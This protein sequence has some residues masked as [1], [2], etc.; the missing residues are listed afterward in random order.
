[1]YFDFSKEQYMAR[2]SARDFLGERLSTTRL[3]QLL[4][5]DTGFDRD[6]WQGLAELGWMS[7]LVPDVH[8]GLGLG[9]LDLALLLE[10]S[11]RA[12][13]PAPIVET[14]VVLPLVLAAA[15]AAQQQ[16]WL[17]RV[18]GG[19]VVATVAIGGRDGLPLPAGAG[20][21]A[22][23]AGAGY[24]L[25]GE[26]ALV[27]FASVA[28]VVLVAARPAGARPRRRSAGAG[29]E[30]SLFLVEPRDRGVSWEP[31]AG[32]DP[33]IRLG[34]LR[35]EGVRV[36]RDRLVGEAGA[37]WG[38]L[39][40]ALRAAQTALALQAVGGAARALDMAVEY[41]KVRRQFGVP[42]GSFQAIKHKCAE[43]L[44]GYET[45]RSGAYYA[46]WAV[47]GDE[48]GA[49]VA[50]AAAKALCT[51][52]FVA[53]AAEAIQVHGGIGFTWEHDLH[54]YFKRAKYLEVALGTPAQ[55]RETIAA[56]LAAGA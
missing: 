30:L 38:A 4:E 40:R 32:L 36:G 13:L 23:R 29:D 43:M 46:A 41:A 35:L 10:E 31:F 48:P 47:D 8:G 45:T 5:S 54:L 6:A 17:P 44:V 28:D 22:R 34:A 51:A 9:F 15:D 1:M 27:P 25:D 21:R 14:A 26:A 24:V 11:G 52:M 55:H 39:A 3:R 50:A 20:V 7:V 37:G 16:R 33:A 56:S 12:L 2:D 49:A 19:E 18:A 53:V 42:I